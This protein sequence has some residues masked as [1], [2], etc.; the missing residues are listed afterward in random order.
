MQYCRP[1][2]YGGLAHSGQMNKHSSFSQ[3]NTNS[4]NDKSGMMRKKESCASSE[5][6]RAQNSKNSARYVIPHSQEHKEHALSPEPPSDVTQQRRPAEICKS[7]KS[8]DL[9][10]GKKKKKKEP[11]PP[12]RRVSLLQP[13][14]ELHSSTKRYSCPT[15]NSSPTSSIPS[16]FS[17]TFVQTSVITGHDPL[18]WKLRPKSSSTTLKARTNRLSLQIPLP[19]IFPDP[20]SSPT[21]NIQSDTHNP[22]PTSKATAV[23]SYSVSSDFLSPRTPGPVTLEDLLDVHLCHVSIS[24]ESEDVFINES[25]KEVKTTARL[26]KSPPPVP[27]KSSMAR[28]VARQIASSRQHCRPEAKNLNGFCRQRTK[29]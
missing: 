3:T 7:E 1:D 11:Q 27:E 2:K 9:I 22:D 24:D 12:Q 8:R 23:R 10:V 21:L 18:G 14:T 26:C 29:E 28:E 5:I 6:C 19:V 13:H 20:K 25:E 15:F 16:H 17:P 4:N